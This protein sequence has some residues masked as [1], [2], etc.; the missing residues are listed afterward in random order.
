MVQSELAGSQQQ[1][2]E[3]SSRLAAAE[4]DKEALQEQLGHLEVKV[5]V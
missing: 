2:A 4:A 3:L 5:G 1:A